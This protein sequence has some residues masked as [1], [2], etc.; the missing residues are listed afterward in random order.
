[1]TTTPRAA[2]RPALLGRVAL[3]TGCGSP[4]GIGFAAARVL[5]EHGATVAIT[6]TTARIDERA[7]DLAATGHTVG[8]FVADLTVMDQAASL[9]RAVQERFGRIDI[10]VNTAG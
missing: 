5:A 10:L 7:A 3:V 6:S 2:G 8:A 4:H 9:V 1:M